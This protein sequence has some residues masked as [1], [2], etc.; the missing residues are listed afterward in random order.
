M[1]LLTWT[2]YWEHWLT[3]TL[4]MDLVFFGAAA[5]FGTKKPAE[6]VS[7]FPVLERLQKTCPPR[8]LVSASCA[9]KSS[10]HGGHQDDE[11]PSG[12][13]KGAKQSGGPSGQ[14]VKIYGDPEVPIP[15]RAHN[16]E[17]KNTM[18]CRPESLGL[19]SPPVP[20]CALC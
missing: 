18:A 20:G 19:P 4:G 3:R 11:S 12:D 9:W 7:R 13:E 15:M 10:K 1:P 6:L 5:S 16:F 17:N 14:K 2:P 8:P